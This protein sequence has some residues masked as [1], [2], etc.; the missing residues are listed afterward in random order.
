MARA[1]STIAD[2][3][4]ARARGLNQYVARMERLFVARELRQAD[5]H[6][7][8]AGALLTFYV[9]LEAS[10]ESVFMGLL[11]GRLNVSAAGFQALVVIRSDVVARKVIRGDRGYVDWL[12]YGHTR[13]RAA[14][15]FS[16]GEPFGSLTSVDA[17]PL[18]NVR[19]V[20][21]ALAH[22]SDQAMRA[23]RKRFVDGRGLPAEQRRPAGYLRGQHAIGQTR[24]EFL[25]ADAVLAVRTLTQ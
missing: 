10:I 15:F 19:L 3:L 1:A 16:R 13:D 9:D 23:F 12:P 2:E 22:G 11:M 25:L 21:N 4:G 5:V 17:Q 24:F 6:R 18:E 8:Y 14:A 20:R 7:A